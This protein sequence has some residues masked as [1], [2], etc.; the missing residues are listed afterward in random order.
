MAKG[1]KQ[2]LKYALIGLVVLVALLFMAKY[3]GWIGADDATEVSIEE[4]SKKTITEIVS[5]NGNV[6]PEVEVKISADVSGEI[7]ELHVK[8]GQ[9]VK[10]GMLLIKIDPDIYLSSVDRVA[11]S[12]NTQK[13]NLENSKSRATQSEAQ[14]L[15]TEL[16]FKRNEKLFKD[17]TISKAEFEEIETAYLVSKAEMDAG[18]Q[19][20]RAAEFNVQSSMATLKEA[21]KNLNKTSIYAPVDG[22]ISRLNVELGERVVGTAQ[23]A[24]TEIMRIANLSEMEV[25]AD[26]GE[27]DI[28]RVSVGDTA[29]I[30]VDAYLDEKFTGIVTEIANS[31]NVSGMSTEQVTNFPVKIRILRESYSELIEKQES[32][33]SPFRP[34]MSATV[35]IST[36]KVHDVLTAPIQAVATRDTTIKSSRDRMKKKEEG[37]SISEKDEEENMK[38]IVFVVDGGEV[39]MQVVKTGIQ[40]NT[41]IEI[42]EG[43]SDG[44]EVVSG[45][46]RAISKTL[47]DGDDIKVVDKE[48]LFK[49]KK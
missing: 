2:I 12:L 39:K 30:E 43:L 40:D 14:F 15:K 7:V 28:I 3:F 27:S 35:E 5:A 48:D 1:E 38:E 21:R 24:G 4:V 22:T 9:V 13:A 47:N 42:L 25:N 8:E 31:A 23:M 45:P 17:G 19:S 37:Q 18:K 16:Q 46:Y 49:E 20:V 44:Q 41:Y 29:E 36:N 32:N 10:K 6:Q 11:A 26:V 33:N 34:G